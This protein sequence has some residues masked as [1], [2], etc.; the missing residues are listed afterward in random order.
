LKALSAEEVEK[1]LMYLLGDDNCWHQGSQHALPPYRAYMQATTANMPSI[2][3]MITKEQEEV[4]AIADGSYTQFENLEERVV[5]TLSYTRTLNNTWNALY[6]P[7][8]VKLT[9]KFLANYDIA[10][11]NDVRSYDRDDDGEL[12]D[13]DVEII[14]IKKLNKKLE[15]NYPYVIRPK[16]DEAV[17]LNIIQRYE[18]LYSTAPEYLKEVTC[19]SAYK[20]YAV[21]G[22]YAKTV[23]ADLDNGNYVY[24][25]NKNG[26][27]QKMGLE[28]SLVPFRI[29]LTMANRDGSPLAP[30][31]LNAQTISMRLVG[32]EA[33]DGT[34]VIYDLEVS[35][36]HAVDYIYQ[37]RCSRPHPTLATAPQA[38]PSPQSRVVGATPHA[39]QARHRAN[40]PYPRTTP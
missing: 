36:E 6:V 11:I 28:T 21:K 33:E 4:V 27:W 2:V 26:Q 29:Y 8:Q 39:M 3:Q 20:E 15:A 18:T 13:W 40:R 12:D 32:E 23:S 5:G 10:Y 30:E 24:A 17:N 35:E 7:F 19:L 34:T 37:P 1:G 14:K 16:N 22:V 25:I 31:E 9:E 38:T